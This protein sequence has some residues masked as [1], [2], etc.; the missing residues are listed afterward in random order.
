MIITGPPQVVLPPLITL[1]PQQ[2][3]LSTQN[4]CRETSDT[5]T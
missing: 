5:W 3:Y 1:F 2:A 4:P